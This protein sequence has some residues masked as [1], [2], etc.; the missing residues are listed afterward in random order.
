MPC[1]VVRDRRIG[2]RAKR[3]EFIHRQRADAEKFP[4][5]LIFQVRREERKR[6]REYL[7]SR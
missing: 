7:A 4:K 6:E 3:R 2:G 5:P 1:I